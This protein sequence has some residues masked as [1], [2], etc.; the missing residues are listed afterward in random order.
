M[1]HTELQLQVIF[2]LWYRRKLVSTISYVLT[3]QQKVNVFIGCECMCVFADIDE[4]VWH[5]VEFKCLHVC[6]FLYQSVHHLLI[7]CL[8]DI[9]PS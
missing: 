5:M 4:C 3:L 7:T 1:Y 8:C 9:I 2:I 6:V